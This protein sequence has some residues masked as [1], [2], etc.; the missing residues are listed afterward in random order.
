MSSVF[1]ICTF[2]ITLICGKAVI[3]T[4]ALFLSMRYGVGDDELELCKAVYPPSKVLKLLE[5][6][7]L[8]TNGLAATGRTDIV[9]QLWNQIKQLIKRSEEQAHLELS[10]LSYCKEPFKVAD[11]L[12]AFSDE[13]SFRLQENSSVR[14][15]RPKHVGTRRTCYNLEKVRG[16]R[17]ASIITQRDWVNVANIISKPWRTT[18]SD[19]IHTAHRFLRIIYICTRR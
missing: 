12:A 16:F 9:Q 14:V 18:V 13:S 17:D 8:H 7:T 1:V 3:H 6:L 4:A 10:S 11:P 15:L 2:C 19:R 5:I